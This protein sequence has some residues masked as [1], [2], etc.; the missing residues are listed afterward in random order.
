MLGWN[1]LGPRRQAQHCWTDASGIGATEF[2][3]ENG[4]LG[5]EYATFFFTEDGLL[6]LEGLDTRP[7][8]EA[9]VEYLLRKVQA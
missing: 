4:E 2:R 7:G 8:M 3:P 5:D 9:A 6:H 1:V